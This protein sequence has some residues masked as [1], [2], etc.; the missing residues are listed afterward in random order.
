MIKMLKYDLKNKKIYEVKKSSIHNIGVYAIEDIPK[1]KTI[2][3]YIGRKISKEESEKIL[4]ERM[5]YHK[6]NPEIA[7]VYIFELNEEYDIDG[8]VPDNDAK[9]VNH[10]CNPNCEVEIIDDEIYIIALRDIKKG[11]EITF[12]YGFEFDEDYIEHP[13]NCGSPNCIGYILAE[14]DWPKLKDYLKNH[15]K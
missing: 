10:S 1:G 15:D 6:K 7:A 8:D 12:N 11:E 2:M 4:N 9:Y 14:E 3:K 13:C 5:K